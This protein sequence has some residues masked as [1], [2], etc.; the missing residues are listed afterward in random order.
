MNFTS[1]TTNIEFSGQDVNME[2]DWCQA[3]MPRLLVWTFQKNK[4]KVLKIKC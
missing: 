4:I 2:I 1:V 3:G